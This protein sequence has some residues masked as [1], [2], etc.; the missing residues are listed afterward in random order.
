MNRLLAKTVTLPILA[1]WDRM[2][3]WLVKWPLDNVLVECRWFQSEEKARG[4]M[5]LLA[6]AT[7]QAIEF[8]SNEHPTLS[9]DPPPF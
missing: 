9:D 6:N 2:T 7:I 1:R 8:N 3:I 5:E 4:F